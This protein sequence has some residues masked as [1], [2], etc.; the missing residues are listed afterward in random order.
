MSPKALNK[1]SSQLGRRTSERRRW[2]YCIPAA[3]VNICTSAS[4]RKRRSVC[5]S[6]ATTWAQQSWGGKFEKMGWV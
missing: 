3:G 5:K 1:V 4:E 2:R 6:G